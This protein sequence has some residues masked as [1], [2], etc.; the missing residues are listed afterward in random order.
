MSPVVSQLS[1]L[2]FWS[3]SMLSLIVTECLWLSPLV[4]V[5]PRL[6]C[7]L[8]ETTNGYTQENLNIEGKILP[9]GQRVLLIPSS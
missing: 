1:P 2:G 7:Q 8:Y 9:E 6:Q 3:G 5:A 4:G